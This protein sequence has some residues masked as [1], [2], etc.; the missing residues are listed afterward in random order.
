[1]FAFGFVEEC[2]EFLANLAPRWRPFV[3]EVSLLALAPRGIYPATTAEEC[4]DA[5]ICHL[6]LRKAWDLLSQLPSLNKAGA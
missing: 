6:S 5:E 1:M 2:C 3:I 4:T